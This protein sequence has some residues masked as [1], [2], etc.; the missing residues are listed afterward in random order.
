MKK[1]NLLRFSVLILFLSFLFFLILVSLNYF[2]RLDIQTTEI[3][4]QTIP[5]YLDMPFSLFSLIGSFEI[6]LITILILW[7][8]KKKLNYFYVLVSFGFF[9]FAEI[10]GKLFVNH[11][12]P[13]FK[14]FRY[15]IPFSMPSSGVNTGS[16]FPSGHM[17]RTVFLSIIFAFM[18]YHSRR[19]S[20]TQKKLFYCFIA[21]IALLMFV[22]RIY[23]GEHWLSDVIGG[24]ILGLAFGVMS[25]ALVF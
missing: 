13:P 21:F 2:N 18:I 22:S 5:R 14:F 7:A 3:L 11:P 25:V 12:N 4:Q 6:V 20:N 8:I 17:G 23:L 1:K 15:D 24:S 16:S 9:H 19:F 10:I